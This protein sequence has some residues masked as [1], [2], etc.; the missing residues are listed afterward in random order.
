[1]LRT[2][3]S[4]FNISSTNSQN[5]T[6]K[7]NVLVTLPNLS[8][9]DPNI[10]N[11]Y[12][13]VLHAEVPNSFYTIN[14]NNNQLVIN[15]IAYSITLGNYNALSLISVLLTLLPVGFTI[16]YSSTTNKYTFTNTS[17]FT[18]N[19]LTT[20][21]KII[22]LAN[23]TSYSSNLKTL[24]LPYPVNFIV[25]P[26]INFKSNVFSFQNHN[27]SDNS[28]D[29]FLSLQNGV[30]QNSMNNYNNNSNIKFEIHN[31]LITSF[32]IIVSNDLGVY[33]D[34]N[35]QDWYMTFQIDID[36][37]DNTDYTL[38]FHSLINNPLGKG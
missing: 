26:R 14:S 7:S 1:M 8:F 4:I 11:V 30:N 18:I 20:C 6:L 21:Y 16:T 29:L 19:S 17:D 32:N 10:K 24:V 36:Y 31:K 2:K 22:G 5:G 28:N 37:L 23:D 9:Q 27:Q 25:F 3:T 12:F 13:S 38:N 35:N 34:F 33:L 15:D